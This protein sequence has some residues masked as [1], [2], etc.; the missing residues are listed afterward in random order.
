MFEKIISTLMS[1]FGGV[2][3]V[4]RISVQDLEKHISGGMGP[5]EQVIDVR[6]PEEFASGHVPG[7]EN[8]PLGMVP[9][10]VDRV[11]GRKRLFVICHSGGRSMQACAQ[12][13]GPLA[14]KTALANVEGGTM[15]WISA[16]FKVEKN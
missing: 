7:A 2:E 14:G 4:E 11:K 15:A 10:S 9:R 1:L 6:E 12:L 5:D 3:G 8:I 13:T 16:G